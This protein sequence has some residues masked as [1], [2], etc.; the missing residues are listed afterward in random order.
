ML[1][2]VIMTLIIMIHDIYVQVLL[3]IYLFLIISIYFSNKIFVALVKI[4]EM[5]K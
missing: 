2:N 1:N 3:F 5:K 4:N